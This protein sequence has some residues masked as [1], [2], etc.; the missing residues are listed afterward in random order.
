MTGRADGA[1]VGDDVANGSRLARVGAERTAQLLTALRPLDEAD[2]AAPS[3]LP[4]WSR[5]T[6]VCHLRYGAHALLRMTRDV[7]A[8]R[9]TAYYP[10]GRVRHRAATLEPASGEGPIDV[11]DD[12]ERTAAELDDEWSRVVDEDWGRRIVEPPDNQDLGPVPLARL[13]L[14]RLTEVDVHGTDLAIGFPDWSPTLVEIALPTRL[15][16]LVDRRSNHRPVDETV[17]GDWLLDA[18]P[19]RRWLVSVHGPDVA[20]RPASEADDPDAVIRGSGRDLLA[21]L[22]G[23]P[24]AEPLRY[25]GDTELASAFPEAFPGP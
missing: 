4:G 21:L 23:R 14:G 7:L 19:D 9:E 11:L 22:L 8:G 18:G 17:E 2:L 1:P 3:A 16:W 12:W 15:R 25:E 5:L 10:G 6:I 20:V 24:P 13:A